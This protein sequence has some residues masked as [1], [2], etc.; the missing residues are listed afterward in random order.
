MNIW[1]KT[2]K[3]I[4][5]NLTHGDVRAHCLAVAAC[6]SALFQLPMM[7]RRI[8]ALLGHTPTQT[9]R[10]WLLL[11]A[12][13]HDL[14]KVDKRFQAKAPDIF[15]KL[16][17]RRP[18]LDELVVY[19]HGP[20]AMVFYAKTAWQTLSA[21]ISEAQLCPDLL[22]NLLCGAWGHHGFIPTRQRGGSQAGDPSR[23]AEEDLEAAASL[24]GEL[25]REIEAV[26]GPFR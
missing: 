21:T 25:K 1:G 3:N 7:Q 18:T 19:Y 24:I 14:G 20:A 2:E 17:G 26:A 16:I 5:R 12:A 11:I 13:L 9:D 6:F 23:P 22:F 8:T 10:S 4:D 15:E